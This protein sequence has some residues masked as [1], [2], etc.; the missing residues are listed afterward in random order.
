MTRAAPVSKQPTNR[1]GF[2]MFAST[3]TEAKIEND[4]QANANA[5]AAG[6]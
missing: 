2:L 4:L 3:T 1:Y 5:D 6:G